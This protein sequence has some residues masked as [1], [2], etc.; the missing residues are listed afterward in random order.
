M[1]ACENCSNMGYEQNLSWSAAVRFYG[2]IVDT[3]SPYINADNWTWL[4]KKKEKYN[5]WYITLKIEQ[6]T[7]TLDELEDKKVSDNLTLSNF[8]WGGERL[9]ARVH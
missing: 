1:H 9:S 8:L 7:N 3:H 2:V 6:Q 5:T 4:Y